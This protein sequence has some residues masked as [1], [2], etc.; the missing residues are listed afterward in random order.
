MSATNQILL[1]EPT[2]LPVRVL[3]LGQV[4]EMTGLP[5][6]SISDKHKAGSRHYDPSFPKPIQLTPKT[7][8]WYQHETV[9]WVM[10]RPR[11]NVGGV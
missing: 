5:A 8:G 1:P 10:Q 3:R 6:T 9:G 11:V 7:L 2:Q 4:S